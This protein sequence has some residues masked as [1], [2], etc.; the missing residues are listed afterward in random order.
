MLKMLHY[1]PEAFAT[2]HASRDLEIAAKDLQL[3]DSKVNDDFLWQH[4][5][6]HCQSSDKTLASR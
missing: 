4:D 6:Q 2:L 1:Y 3:A 5:A